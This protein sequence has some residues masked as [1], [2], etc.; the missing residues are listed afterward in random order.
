MQAYL[1]FGSR[2]ALPEHRLRPIELDDL[3]V[4]E[5]LDRVLDKGIV[6]DPSARVILLSLHLHA[7]IDRVVVE[8]VQMHVRKPS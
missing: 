2:K 7:P 1:H 8:S 3:N 5:I 4:S 6:V